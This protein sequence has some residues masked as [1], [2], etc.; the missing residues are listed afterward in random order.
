[1]VL[2]FLQYKQANNK[3]QGVT[4]YVLE[5]DP[6][7]DDDESDDESKPKHEIPYW[8]QRTYFLF[9]ILKNYCF[10]MLKNYC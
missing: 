5:S 8:A 1:M 7:D 2:F 6:D 4:H 9:S 10:S 3:N